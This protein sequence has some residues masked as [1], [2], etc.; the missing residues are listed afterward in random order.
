[1]MENE[2]VGEGEN[3]CAEHFFLKGLIAS[4]DHVEPEK[5]SLA[6]CWAQHPKY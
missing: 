6:I 3:T 5:W 1:M 2:R 4:N